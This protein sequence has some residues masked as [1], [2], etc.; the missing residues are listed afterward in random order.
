MYKN[1]IREF[2][3]KSVDVDAQGYIISGCMSCG[4][5]C[6][7]LI[8]ESRVFM[9]TNKGW[10]A[11]SDR[12]ADIVNYKFMQRCVSNGFSIKSGGQR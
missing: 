11:L 5:V 10:R 3:I 2:K 12:I 7:F 1:K 4:K 9:E 6:R 8:K